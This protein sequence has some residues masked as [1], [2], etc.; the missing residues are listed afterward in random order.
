M[1]HPMNE[2]RAHKVEKQRVKHIT[3]MAAGGSTHSDEAMDRSLIKRMVKKT[4]MRADGGAVRQRADRPARAKGGRVKGTTVNVIVAPKEKSDMPAMPPMGAMPPPMPPR[5]PAMPPAPVQAGPPVPGL[6]GMPPGGPP[7]RSDGGRA[8]KRGGGVKDKMSSE[9]KHGK[10]KYKMR[11]DGG[12][13]DGKEPQPSDLYS[14]DQV[15]RLEKQRASGGAVSDSSRGGTKVQHSGNKSDSQNIGRGPVITK[16][17]G[18]PVY[19]D[20]RIGKQMAW[21]KGVGSGGG[22]GRLK[23]AHHAK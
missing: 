7:I 21:L 17:T 13:S 22:E 23:K 15:K 5:P 10:G 11:A 16:A 20:G 9:K 8:Y 18:G 3:G 6:G 4:A 1:A 12:R 14:P 2:H 19:S